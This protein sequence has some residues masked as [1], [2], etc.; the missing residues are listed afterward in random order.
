[1]KDF[2]M[3]R[4]FLFM[5][6]FIL[7][8]AA[9]TGPA[10]ANQ[11]QSSMSNQP[12]NTSATDKKL[13]VAYFSCSGN[14]EQVAELIAGQTGARLYKITPETPYTS[15]DLNYQNSSSRSSREQNDPSARPALSGSVQDIQN[16]DVVFVGYPTWWGQAPKVILSFLE[17]HNLG[18]KTIVPFTTS[19]SSPLGSSDANLHRFAPS[20]HWK[21]GIRFSGQA[22]RET[23]N[24]WIKGLNL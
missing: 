9:L 2:V 6:S 17:S 10:A 18:G 22:S 7:L 23:V 21:P 19:H 12:N 5:V 20:A 24:A 8:L 15:A 11:E 4:N 16:Y 14:T 13:L 1:M 3:T